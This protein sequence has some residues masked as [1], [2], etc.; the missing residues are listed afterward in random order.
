MTRIS[1]FI[2]ALLLLMS[3]STKNKQ[4]VHLS[5]LTNYINVHSVRNVAAIDNEMRFWENRLNKVPDDVA[6]RNKLA[7]LLA[8]RFSQSGNIDE[9]H[10][11][12]S[13][14]KL[15]LPLNRKT[16]SATFRSLASIC[17]SQHKFKEAEAYIDSALM[18]GDDRYLS[19]LMEFD[20]AMELGNVARAK[21]ALQSIA[22]K[23]GFDYLI[24]EAKYKDH[25]D[26]DLDG[27]ISSMEKAFAKI[28]DD[29]NETLYLWAKSNLGDMYGH[30]NRFKESYKC[31][32]DVLEKDPEYHHALKGIAWL[33]F[34]HD[35][36]AELA[37]QILLALQSK[38]P[39]P[40]YDLMLAEIAE[41]ENNN[42]ARE[43]Y[44]QR[45]LTSVGNEKYGDM[46]NKYLIDIVGE[47]EAMRIA[48]REVQNR[49]TG[50]S[51]NL[52]AWT[53]YLNGDVDKAY[54]IV[55]TNVENWC[56][57]PDALYHMGMIN[58][59]KGE[60]SKAKEY[61]LEAKQSSYELG[62]S[63]TKNIQDTLKKL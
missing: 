9:L 16:N 58:L 27:A 34:S 13:I 32:L 20:V 63:I 4:I 57:E 45:F 21:K 22:D 26:G 59:A 33:A 50:E 36:N 53:Y 37:K 51:Y 47:Q 18:L 40:D 38:H 12:D 17:V 46:Y 23:K 11:A 44:Q 25:V 3:C 48:K 30:A 31:Y 35:K 56:F 6:S 60:K 49:P 43:K 42:D 61:L 54:D 39:V 2:A 8:N 5:D 7:S 14:Y 24:R 62:P 52:L 41:Y 19:I 15:V 55:R 1:F 10:Q 29:G 28:K